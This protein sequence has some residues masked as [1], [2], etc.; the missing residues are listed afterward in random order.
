MTTTTETIETVDLSPTRIVRSMEFVSIHDSRV[1]TM[2]PFGHDVT[3]RLGPEGLTE[4]VFDRNYVALEEEGDTLAQAGHRPWCAYPDH[5]P[6][7]LCGGFE[8]FTN[9]DGGKDGVP[10]AVMVQIVGGHD[11][12]DA[13]DV[14]LEGEPTAQGAV[15]LS[16]RAV[17]ELERTLSEIRRRHDYFDGVAR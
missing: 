16:M 3:R 9:G 14:W 4:L 1:R 12:P 11:K 2:V 10:A 6:E 13:V 17:F 5:D 15:R 8:E 7:L